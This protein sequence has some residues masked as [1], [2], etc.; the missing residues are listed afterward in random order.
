MAEEQDALA[1]NFP[2]FMNYF[3]DSGLDYHV[4]VV[5]TD[6]DAAS[7]SGKLRMDGG[8][9]WIDD[10]NTDPLGAFARM[11]SMGVDGSADEQGIGAAYSALEVRRYDFNADFM[12]DDASLHIVIISDEDDYTKDKT[13]S[14]DEFVQYLTDLKPDPEM[15]TFSSIVNEPGCCQGFFADGEPGDEYIE[16]TQEVGGILW[17]LS[18]ENW[19]DVLE[20]LGMQAAGLKREFFLS[21]LPV[22]GTITV[23]IKEDGSTIELFEGPDW[24]YNQ[25]R[26][27]ISL[28]EYVPTPLAEVILD[29]ELL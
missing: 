18:N 15:V 21:Q 24:T 7:D 5:S 8:N 20:Q 22:P 23:K 10:E 1:T 9:R 29:Y 11:A 4:G 26:N 17:P 6:M 28:V 2:A 3:T 19:A 13:I 16:T 25:P 12:R 27:S 14:Q